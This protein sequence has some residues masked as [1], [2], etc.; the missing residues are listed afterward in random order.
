MYPKACQ[1]LKE[2]IRKNKKRDVIVEH[3]FERVYPSPSHHC[4]ARRVPCFECTSNNLLALSEI[5]PTL[6]IQFLAEC[7]VGQPEEVVKARVA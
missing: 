4:R 1:L 7:D 6:R 3:L 5:Q 2:L